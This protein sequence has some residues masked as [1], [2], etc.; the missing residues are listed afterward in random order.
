M[1]TV[2]SKDLGGLEPT[3]AMEHCTYLANTT[4]V[5]TW[6]NNFRKRHLVLSNSLEKEEHMPFNNLPKILFWYIV[7]W[8][9]VCLEYFKVV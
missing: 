7:T 1:K 9:R 5:Y 4:K 8:I 2:L 6:L 3:F